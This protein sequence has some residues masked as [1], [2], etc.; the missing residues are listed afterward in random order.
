MLSSQT[1]CHKGTSG[2][3]Q[4]FTA[5]YKDAIPYSIMGIFFTCCILIYFHSISHY[6]YSLTTQNLDP[7][8]FSTVIQTYTEEHM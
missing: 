4:A 1:G 5:Y 6:N 3:E 7:K 8:Y 2:K